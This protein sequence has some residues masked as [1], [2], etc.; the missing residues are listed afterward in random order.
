[1]RPDPWRKSVVHGPA[2]NVGL[3]DSKTFLNLMP[4]PGYS[5]NLLLSISTFMGYLKGESTLMIYDRHPN[6]QN[7]WNRT[8]WARDY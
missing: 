1:M 7:K 8:F 5:K 4:F 6:L 3:H 2:V